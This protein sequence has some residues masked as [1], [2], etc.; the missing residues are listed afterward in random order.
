MA[1]ITKLLSLSD[2][3]TFDIELDDGRIAHCTQVTSQPYSNCTF[4]AGAVEGI[5]PDTLYFMAKRDDQEEPYIL[6]LRPD[7]MQAIAWLCNGALWSMAIFGQESE[8]A[9]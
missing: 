4:S 3:D 2:A 7:E 9:A 1:T 6:F 8:E 5:D